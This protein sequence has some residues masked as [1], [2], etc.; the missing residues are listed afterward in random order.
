[1]SDNSDIPERYKCLSDCVN[2]MTTRAMSLADLQQQIEEL[3]ALIERQNV[4][5]QQANEQIA[6]LQAASSADARTPAIQASAQAPA[7]NVQ[8]PKIPD[9]IRLVPEFDGNP[10]NLS[11]WIESVEQ[12]LEESKRFIAPS[13]QPVILPIWLGIIRDKV[14][15]KANDA[16]TASHTPLEWGSIKN[17]LIEYFGDKSDLSILISRLTSLKQGSLSVTEF[18]QT[19]RNLLADIN[20]KIMIGNNTANEAKAIMGTYESLMINAFVDGLHDTISDLTRSTR[21]QSLL[22]AYHVASEHEAAFRRRR[23]KNSKNIP[24]SFKQKQNI[25]APQQKPI[26]LQNTFRPPIQGSFNSSGYRQVPQNSPGL[27]PQYN[28]GIARPFQQNFGPRPNQLAIP[29]IKTDPS[30]QNRQIGPRQVPSFRST[31]QVNVHEMQEAPSGMHP[32][33]QSQEF[34]YVQDQNMATSAIEEQTE[35]LNFCTDMEQ[36]VTE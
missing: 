5:A 28:N 22:D 17:T 18:Y 21:P 27:T 23:E 26:Y 2:S 6:A 3:S 25:T 19:C 13:D 30:G 20:A 11:R 15:E 8:F 31:T 35:E 32:N 9:L 12:K 1:M 29:Y 10:R 7:A 33:D 14:T 4:Q 24:D 36:P 34:Q 16:L